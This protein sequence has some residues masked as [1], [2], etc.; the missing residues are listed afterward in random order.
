[1]SSPQN[2]ERKQANFSYHHYSLTFST[3]QICDKLKDVK[4]V[5]LTD[6][7]RRADAQLD[8]L[9]KKLFNYERGLPVYK[10]EKLTGTKSRFS[11]SKIGPVLV[12]DCG[13]GRASVSIALHELFLMCK[14]SG[15]IEDIKL[16]RF[17]TCEYF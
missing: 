12:S 1:M 10:P 13:L 5:L 8:Y 17:G 14:Q 6:C 16:I 15:I 4:I 7:S 2:T 11:L 9:S 3:H